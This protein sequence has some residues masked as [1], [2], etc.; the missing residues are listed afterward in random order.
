MTF[1]PPSPPHDAF[2]EDEVAEVLVD[3]DR[4]IIP[5]VIP[6]DEVTDERVIASKIFLFDDNYV[7]SNEFKS[8][9]L[10]EKPNY[11]SEEEIKFLT[12]IVLSALPKKEGS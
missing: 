12:R 4:A 3:I 11:L 6:G 5:S 1:P 7:N 10:R 9:W 8:F 2:R